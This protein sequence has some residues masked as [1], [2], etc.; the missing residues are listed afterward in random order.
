[1]K[2]DRMFSNI[3]ATG[4]Y[5]WAPS[6]GV[7]CDDNV[8]IN[9]DPIPM[10]NNLIWKKE[11]VIQKRMKFQISPMMFVTWLEGLICPVVAT[12]AAVGREKKENVLRFKLRKKRILELG[13]NYCHVRIN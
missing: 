9:E 2:F 11:A 13:H 7:L 1:M 5:T 6:S 4:E 3:V 10:R 12:H 8:G